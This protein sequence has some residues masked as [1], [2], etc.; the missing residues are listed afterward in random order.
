MNLDYVRIIINK[1]RFPEIDLTGQRKINCPYCGEEAEIPHRE[2]TQEK[3][4]HMRSVE[5]LYKNMEGR[6]FPLI[7][8]FRWV[9]C[10]VC[11]K[12]F[13]GKDK[14]TKIIF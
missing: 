7:I 3:L 6:E 13:I 8:N 2:I 10:P 4:T 1:D 9:I 12:M 11:K 14:F 5:T